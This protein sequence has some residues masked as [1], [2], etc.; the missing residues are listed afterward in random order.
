MHL[1]LVVCE[2]RIK[3]THPQASRWIRWNMCS[4]FALSF[5][6]FVPQMRSYI[7]SISMR[8]L[9]VLITVFK[10]CGVLDIETST[11]KQLYSSALRANPF[12]LYLIPL[13][14]LWCRSSSSSKIHFLMK[15]NSNFCS[16]SHCA[17]PSVLLIQ[18]FWWRWK[19]FLNFGRF[20][21]HC[22]SVWRSNRML[23]WCVFNVCD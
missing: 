10:W 3:S 18:P 22:T 9:L 23:I 5:Y 12:R 6:A 15:A 2:K 8:K 4:T 13:H 19:G 7:A 16:C 21:F 20:C 11:R 17:A 14:R 1:A